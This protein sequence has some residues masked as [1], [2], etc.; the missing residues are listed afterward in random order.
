MLKI[1][2]LHSVSH[3][4]RKLGRFLPLGQDTVLFS[5][6]QTHLLGHV[7]CQCDCM[8]QFSCSVCRSLNEF[9]LQKSLGLKAV[10][11]LLVRPIN[12]IAER[13]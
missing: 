5:M 11:P 12:V 13:C 4:L 9:Q 8:W 1:L 10:L 3:H 2:A 7:G 6:W